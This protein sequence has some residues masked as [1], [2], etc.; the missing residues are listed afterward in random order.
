MERIEK[1][2]SKRWENERKAKEAR[3]RR[4]MNGRVRDQ[5]IQDGIYNS[6]ATETDLRSLVGQK[7]L[8]I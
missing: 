8:E 1:E 5:S 4:K 6:K 7:P 2:V 3:D